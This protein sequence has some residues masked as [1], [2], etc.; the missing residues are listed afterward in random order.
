[1]FARG[2]VSLHTPP[3][4]GQKPS[5][6]KSRVSISSKLIEIKGLQLQH[7]GHLRK[8]GGRGV[9]LAC[10]E[11]SRRA[12]PISSVS[13]ALP[14]LLATHHAFVF[15][16]LRTLS[17]FIPSLSRVPAIACALFPKKPGGIPPA[18]SY[19]VASVL[20]KGCRLIA[21]GCQLSPFFPLH[22]QKPGGAPPQ[23]CRRADIFDFSPYI[24]HFFTLCANRLPAAASAEAGR[25]TPTIPEEG[26]DHCALNLIQWRIT[27]R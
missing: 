6:A 14:S 24:L 1:M 22:T 10:P 7:F 16:R 18:R 27:G 5:S 12:I 17:F 2:L 19:Q 25:L 4:L 13:S 15:S 9:P 8:T 11:R 23:K 26:S 3:L 21:N 20:A